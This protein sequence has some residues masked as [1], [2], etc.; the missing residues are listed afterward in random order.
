MA[1]GARLFPLQV[2]KLY[3]KMVALVNGKSKKPYKYYYQTKGKKEKS[4][5]YVYHDEQVWCKE[6]FTFI[7]DRDAFERFLNDVADSQW[8][9]VLMAYQRVD[10]SIEIPCFG[11]HKIH[12]ATYEA[13]AE[14]NFDFNRMTARTPDEMR[15]RHKVFYDKLR[16]M[17]FLKLT[18]KAK[19]DAACTQ[20]F[21]DLLQ[22]GTT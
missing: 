3:E 5:V 18:D 21:A 16:E 12:P 15:M 14:V 1:K 11:N 17:K 8:M 6:F 9:S 7:N 10:P 13:Y 19:Y 22:R 2:T 20:R 4:F